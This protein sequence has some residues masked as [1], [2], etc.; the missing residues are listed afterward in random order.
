[1]IA[2]TEAIVTEL[3]MKGRKPKISLAFILQSFVKLPPEDIRLNATY[4][5]IMKIPNK[6]ESCYNQKI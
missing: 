3:F 2:D 5:F 6:R 4:L 1:M